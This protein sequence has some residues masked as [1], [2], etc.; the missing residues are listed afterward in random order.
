MVYRG[1]VVPKEADAFNLSQAGFDP[2]EIQAIMAGLQGYG[3]VS[4]C[5]VS[6]QATPDMTVAV[7]AGS[8]ASPAGT[9]SVAAGNATIGTADGTNPRYDLVVAAYSS[10]AVSVLAGSPAAAA[11]PAQLHPGPVWPAGFDPTTYPGLAV[12]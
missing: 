4:G 7:A 5:G 6:A 8:V 10:G 3:V 2:L 1:L 9:V 12:A 11:D